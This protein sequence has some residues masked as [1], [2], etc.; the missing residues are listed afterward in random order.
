M[1]S[2]AYLIPRV[3]IL[4]LATLALALGADPIVRY[5]MIS[6]LEAGVGAKVHI[7]RISSDLAKGKIYL[8]DFSIAD[9][10]Q[11]MENLF[12]SDL[13]YLKFDHSRLLDRQ[14]VIDQARTSHVRFGA[15][16]TQDGKLSGVMPISTIA[17]TTD[18]VLPAPVEFA[19][20][21][22]EFEVAWLGQF[23]ERYQSE[24][25]GEVAVS[26]YA[27]AKSTNERWNRDFELHNQQ[28]DSV[29]KKIIQLID[30]DPE[31]YE[32]R[33]ATPA[34]QDRLAAD[35]RPVN[36]LRLAS[37]GSVDLQ[38]LLTQTMTA[39]DD[40]KRQQLILKKNA[41]SDIEALDV[42]F[43]ADVA[44]ISS[45]SIDQE[46][47]VL[48]QSINNLLLV[49]F[50]QETAADAISWFKWLKNKAKVTCKKKAPQRGREFFT[51]YFQTPG[52]VINEAEI[53]GEGIFAREHF[54]FAG[55]AYNLSSDA[56]GH[57]QPARFDL[58]AQ[59]QHHFS[60]NCEIDQ[61][62]DQNGPRDANQ[63]VIEFPSFDLEERILGSE[64]EMQV[65]MSSGTK[66]SGTIKINID[67]DALSGEMELNFSN[68]A[69]VVQHLN[70]IA[71]GKE[72]EIRLNHQL[73]TL[74]HFQTITQ[75]SGDVLSPAL[76]LKSDLGPSVAM[77]IE[78]VFDQTKKNS[79]VVRSRKIEEFYRS[80]VR[81]LQQNIKSE[82]EKITGTLDDQI[83]KTEVIQGVQ[84]AAST[85]KSRWPAIR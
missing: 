75:I 15:P 28:L 1:K 18:K 26:L 45:I 33:D 44:A 64:N 40:L 66:V 31:L 59:G 2:F 36:P 4:G 61:R 21:Q 62:R 24:Q 78:S 60:L 84:R 14:V 16:R 51:E 19:S 5:L 9:P 17:A 48:P 72:V 43:K 32:F 69:L 47:G 54:H 55:H 83:S 41:Q 71:G 76:E 68:V 30:A 22:S 20:T 74:N 65:S 49:Q 35:G 79:Q 25:P 50:H 7:G 46:I 70:E 10:E 37:T 6:N 53:D 39:I 82:V 73:S 13:T 34:H 8:R 38:S 67:G 42:A 63:L 52:L 3:F 11:P 58:R 77:A 29:N 56:Q 85:A 57:D 23:K 12:Q 81:P 27:V 80:R